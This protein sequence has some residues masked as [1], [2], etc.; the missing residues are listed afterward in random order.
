MVSGRRFPK[1]GF[2]AALLAAL[3]VL[4]AVPQARGNFVYWTSGSPSSSIARAKLNG[5]A[6]NTKFIPGLNSP[7]G[8]ATDSRFIYWTQG[9]ATNGSI[10]RANLD[11][12]GA[13]AQFIPHSAGVGAPSGIAVTPTAIF[14]QH[15]GNSIGRAN[16][17]GSAPNPNFIATTNSNCGLTADSNFLYFLNNGGTQIGRATLDG[18]SV[19]P[20]FASIPEAFCGLSADYNYLYWASDSGNTVGAVPVVG[21]AADPDYVPA[22]TMGGGPSGVAVNSQFIFWGNYD[23]GAIAR[24]NLNGSAPKLGL[25]PDAGVTGPPNPSQLTAAPANKITVNSVVSNRKKGTAT[26]QARVPSPGVVTMDETNTAPDAGASAA[27]VQQVSMEL[28]RA[29]VFELTVKAIG[30]TA[31]KLKKRVLKRGKGRVT[32]SVFIHF[33]PSTVAGV[34]NTEPVAVTLIKKGRRQKHRK[35][36]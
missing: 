3:T 32:V 30:K 1:A 7:H 19:A 21:G 20:D 22:G 2:V 28:P 11:G 14:W 5:S 24:A 9:D 10:G 18:A 36:T 34:P 29:E 27:A 35:K 23:T 26:I 17:D 31:K 8:V 16:I 12:S 6:L 13:N 33:V 15:D 25:I 4:I